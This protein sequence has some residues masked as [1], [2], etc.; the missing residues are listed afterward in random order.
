MALIDIL[1]AVSAHS[2]VGRH[3]GAAAWT[4]KGLCRCL[5]VLVKIGE[6]NHQVGGHDWKRE[7]DLDFSLSRSQLHLLRFVPTRRSIIIK[8]NL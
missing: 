5:V 4:L 7:V 6:L 3:R 8:Y 2:W 1:S